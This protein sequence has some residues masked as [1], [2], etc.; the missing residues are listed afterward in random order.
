MTFTRE[1]ITQFDLPPGTAGECILCHFSSDNFQ[2][3]TCS[4]HDSI[5]RQMS[6]STMKENSQLILLM[7]MV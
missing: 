3:Y 6:F 7:Q 5:G 4:M 1:V 2:Q